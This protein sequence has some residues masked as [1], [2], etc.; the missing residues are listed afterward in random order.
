MPEYDV[1]IRQGLVVDGTGSPG[2]VADVGIL[3]DRIVEVTEKLSG[4]VYREVDA[5]GLIVTPGFIDPHTH[6]DGQATWDDR[7]DPAFGHGV[8][9]AVMGNCGVGFAPVRPGAHTEL[10]DI[11]EGVEDIPGT[12][13]Y[14]GMPWGEWESYPE[15]LAY[16]RGR[17]FSLDLGSQMAHGAL[18]A[19]VMGVESAYEKEAD[20]EQV[21]HMAALVEE[22]MRAGALGLSTNRISGHRGLSGKQVP[23]TFAEQDELLALARAMGATGAGVLQAVPGE[24]VGMNPEAGEDPWRNAEEIAMLGRISRATGRPVTFS[25]AQTYEDPVL[26]RQTL[27]NAEREIANGAQL[28]PQFAARPPGIICGL[29]AY[30]IFQR[31]ETFLWLREMPRDHMIAEMRKP[32]VKSAILA[33]RNVPDERP[34]SMENM[35][36][37][38]LGNLTGRFFSIGDPVDYEPLPERTVAAVA[39]ARGESEESVLYDCLLEADGRNFMLMPFLNYVDGN[40]DAIREMF[41]H[42]RTI[43]GLSD[44]GAHVKLICDASLPTYSLTHWVRD[45]SRGERLPLGFVVHKLTS[46]NADL[47]Q[48]RDRG[49]IAPGLRAD[50]N[51]IDLEALTLNLPHMRWDLPTGAGRLLQPAHGYRATF[52]AGVQT[53]SDDEDTGARPGRLLGTA[54]YAG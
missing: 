10:I 47:H 8:T 35:I 52:V 43:S 25:M 46:H 42:P 20:A 1:V 18:R 34:G 31:R 7:L 6:F 27:K 44:A 39:A 26:W 15:Y 29:N 33:D 13:L 22:G 14:E 5:E 49:R 51:V 17:R 12:A 28:H 48:M 11:M 38:M 24:S 36:P 50:L 3:G 53:V 23:G 41:S 30:H 37:E 21:E 40:H 2:R 32:E 54:A 9:T 4:S 45:R 16:L 19:Y